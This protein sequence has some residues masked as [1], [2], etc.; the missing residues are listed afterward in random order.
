M[1][2]KNRPRCPSCGKLMYRAKA[3]GIKVKKKDPYKYC[4][5]TECPSKKK[6]KPKPRVRKTEPKEGQV[7]LAARKIVKRELDSEASPFL[8]TMALVAQE[9]EFNGLANFLIDKF[10]LDDFYGILKRTK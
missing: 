4:R 9:M 10:G 1:A 6:K 7:I 5:N 8:L 2:K 3:K